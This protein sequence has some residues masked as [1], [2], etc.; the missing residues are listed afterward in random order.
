MEH[1][2]LCVCKRSFLSLAMFAYLKGIFFLVDAY[3]H[4]KKNMLLT[5]YE[6]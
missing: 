1:N 5:I 3:V 2:E 4:N 6:S